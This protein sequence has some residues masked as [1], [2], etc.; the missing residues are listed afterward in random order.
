MTHPPAYIFRRIISVFEFFTVTM[1][2]I[3]LIFALV[4]FPIIFQKFYTFLAEHGYDFAILNFAGR[5]FTDLRAL[6]L[7]SVAFIMVSSAYYFL[8]NRK[9]KFSLTFP[10]SSAV[11][12][13]WYVFSKIF[14]YYVK[15]FPQV[16]LIYGSIAG[17]II[18]LL[19]FYA[20]SI[21]L[22][23]GA[24]LNYHLQNKYFKKK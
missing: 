1:F 7:V 8:P 18:A 20:C 23:F 24:E 3:F 22:I 9:Q 4:V 13:G 16:N 11:L 14:A 17:I 5:E 21:I 12:V 10:G 6:L 19:Y 2:I 15:Y